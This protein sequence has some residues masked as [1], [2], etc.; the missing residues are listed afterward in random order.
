MARISWALVPIA[1]GIASLAACDSGDISTADVEKAA[2]ERAR[3]QLG[4]GPEVPLDARVWVGRE[5]A[6]KMTYCGSVQGKAG[7]ESIPPQRFAA[8]G[9][10]MTF[11][12]F[13]DA[14]ATDT[15]SQPGK[16]ESWTALCAGQQS[17]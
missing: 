12:I 17:A 7:G 8:H 15:A 3:S 1:L 2:V 11:F 5:A 16:F 6:G 13:E 9:G 10:P 14:H 4:L